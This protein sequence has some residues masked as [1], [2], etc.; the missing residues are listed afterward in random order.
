MNEHILP[1][2]T[3]LE[4]PEGAPGEPEKRAEGEPQPKRLLGE[5]SRASESLAEVLDALTAEKRELEARLSRVEAELERAR[6]EAVAA[7]SEGAAA[8]EH[9]RKE[10]TAEL[11]RART[12]AADAKRDAADAVDRARDE[13]AAQLASATRTAARN[14]ARADR[15]ERLLAMVGG[16]REAATFSVTVG[17]SGRR[18]ASRDMLAQAVTDGVHLQLN[19]HDT[20]RDSLLVAELEGDLAA[21]QRYLTWA[22]DRF[23]DDDFRERQP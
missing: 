15:A 18:Q 3:R 8:V 12:A 16:L 7:K 19:A 13:A 10:A 6:A 23:A 9:A 17:R 20:W 2:V 14:H 11:E 5:L 22:R 4:Q 1:A 21:L